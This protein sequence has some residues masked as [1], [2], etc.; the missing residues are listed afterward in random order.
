MGRMMITTDFT[1]VLSLSSAA[2]I[3]ALE[4]SHWGVGGMV[5]GALGGVV[6]G[7]GAAAALFQ[8]ERVVFTSQRFEGENGGGRIL[9]CMLALAVAAPVLTASASFQAARA[10][11][12][13]FVATR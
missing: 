13:Y 2:L 6:I 1:A 8:A 7:F 5:V 11:G 9:L 3:G 10:A 12:G 4:G